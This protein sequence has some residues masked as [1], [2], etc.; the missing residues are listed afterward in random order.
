MGHA[1]GRCTW[2]RNPPA[3]GAARAPGVPSVTTEAHQLPRPELLQPGEQGQLKPRLITSFGWIPDTLKKSGPSFKK[4]KTTPLL[5]AKFACTP[6]KQCRETEPHSFSF[7]TKRH[8]TCFL[9]AMP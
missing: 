4:K 8:I 9:K 1:M 6:H 3:A 5:N 2:E 7:Q